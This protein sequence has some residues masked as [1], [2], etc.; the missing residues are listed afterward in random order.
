VDG[1]SHSSRRNGNDNTENK[2]KLTH[3]SADDALTTFEW[4]GCM[5]DMLVCCFG[6]H[7]AIAYQA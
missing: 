7:N 2:T 4:N 1:S 5:V 3:G 6:G